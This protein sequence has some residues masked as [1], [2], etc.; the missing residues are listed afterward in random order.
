MPVEITRMIEGDIE[1]AIDCIQKAFAQ[2]PYF[3]WVFPENVRI[4][5]I[6]L[7]TILNYTT[8]RRLDS[9]SLLSDINCHQSFLRHAIASRSVFAVDGVLSTLCST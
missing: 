8:T 9:V 7:F 5:T 3:A 6:C 1:G 4:Y 2:D